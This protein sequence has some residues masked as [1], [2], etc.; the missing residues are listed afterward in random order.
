MFYFVDG[1]SVTCGFIVVD[2]GCLFISV[3]GCGLYAALW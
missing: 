1:F 2:A 3:V